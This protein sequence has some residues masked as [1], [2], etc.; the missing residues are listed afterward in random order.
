MV[1]GPTAVGKSAFGMRMASQLDGEIVSADSRQVYRGFDIGTAKATSG[2]RASVPHHLVDILEPDQ[3]YGLLPFLDLA[4]KAIEEISA[5]DRLPV[6]VG[7][8][9]QYVFALMEGWNPDRVP[10]NSRLRAA[11]Q[12]RADKEG[13]RK[14]HK[15]LA[16]I[17]AELAAQIDHRNTRRVIRALEIRAHE[18]QARWHVTGDPILDSRSQ[19]RARKSDCGAGKRGEG[20]A[21]IAIAIGLTL[22][23]DELY[24]RIDA[25][26][27][28]MIDRGWLKEVQTLLRRGY[29]ADLSSMSSIGYWELAE[30]IAGRTDYASAVQNIKHRSHRLARSQYVWLR[31]ATWLEWFDADKEGLRRAADRVGEQIESRC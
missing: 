20:L 23:R 26:V 10:P 5:R 7:G 19:G 18:D 29:D 1:A 24:R 16:E 6:V 17:D 8:S 4:Q 27:D 22:P 31:R 3:E 12:R 14:L 25:R 11:L 2:E 28:Q 30:H 15:D 21:Q 13:S 9:S